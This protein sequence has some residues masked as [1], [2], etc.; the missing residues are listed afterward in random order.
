MKFPVTEIR[1]L[2]ILQRAICLKPVWRCEGYE[3]EHEGHNRES[4]CIFPSFSA[5][6]HFQF[7]ITFAV[8]T[9]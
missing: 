4:N 1:E 3:D 9:N 5:S 2:R 7:C 6:A 8:V